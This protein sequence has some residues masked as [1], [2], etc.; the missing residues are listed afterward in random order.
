MI[1]MSDGE[2]FYAF[3]ENT[4]ISDLGASCHIT[5]DTIDMYY[6]TYT[7][8]SIQGS[9]GYTKA[10]KKGKICIKVRHVD[11]SRRMHTM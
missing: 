4:W 11:E 8:E 2:T 10:T 5:D 7:G 6:T 3:T 9:L 1:C